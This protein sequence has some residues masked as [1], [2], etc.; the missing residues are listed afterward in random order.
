M[1]EGQRQTAS[2]NTGPSGAGGPEEPKSR[3]NRMYYPRYTGL[4]G[5]GVLQCGKA[6]E[7]GRFLHQSDL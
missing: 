2:Q 1:N 7:G 5:A 4:P 6:T 3:T